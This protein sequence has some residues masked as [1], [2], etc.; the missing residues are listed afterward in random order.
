M[1][2]YNITLII[3]SIILGTLSLIY[4]NDCD[5][6]YKN[7]NYKNIVL[8]PSN[9]RSLAELSHTL[10][11]N[12]MQESNKLREYVNMNE[13]IYKKN[14]YPN[15]DAKTKQ[16]VPEVTEKENTAKENLEQY[17][18]GSYDNEKEANSNRSSCS[19]K[20]L[21]MQRKLYNNFY[22]KPEIYFEHFSDK[23]NDK[24]CECANKKKSSNQLFSSNNVNDTYLD[25]FKKVY[26]GSARICI[27][28]SA[29]IEITVAAAAG[30]A[31]VTSPA[32]YASVTGTLVLILIALVLIILYIWSHKRRKNSWK[33]EYKK[34]LCT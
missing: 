25:N 16:N 5:R 11:G 17:R 26:V 21:E 12:H 4:N 9:Y 6:L 24:Y 7:I 31:S 29:L 13:T 34:H 8:V 10:T 22:V 2:Y 20:Y 18:K 1:I 28:S 15:D 33:H 3:F 32:L 30:K 23:S 19:L 14:T 27:F